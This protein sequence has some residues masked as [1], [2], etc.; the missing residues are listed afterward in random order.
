MSGLIALRTR[1][2][3]YRLRGELAPPPEPLPAGVPSAAAF[4]AAG[5]QP[6]ALSG[7]I[8]GGWEFVIAAYTVSAV[9]LIGYTASVYMRYRKERARAAAEDAGVAA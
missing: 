7:Q 3:A 9:V 2:A 6:V 8:Q 5:L 1:V 4:A